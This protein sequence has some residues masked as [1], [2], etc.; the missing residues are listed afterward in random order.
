MVAAECCSAMWAC[1]ICPMR[2]GAQTKRGFCADP[3]ACASALP[4][5]MSSSARR[6]GSSR[7]GGS[8]AAD[9]GPALDPVLGAL[10]IGAGEQVYD[11]IVAGRLP[12]MPRSCEQCGPYLTHPFA[13]SP[14]SLDYDRQTRLH[15]VKLGCIFCQAVQAAAQPQQPT[16]LAALRRRPVPLATHGGQPPAGGGGGGGSVAAGWLQ[17]LPWWRLRRLPGRPSRRRR[18]LQSTLRGLHTVALADGQ[19]QYLLTWAGR[20]TSGAWFVLITLHLAMH[21]HWVT[22]VVFTSA[23][24]RAIGVGMDNLQSEIRCFPWLH[25]SGGAAAAAAADG[26]RL[27]AALPRPRRRADCA[28]PGPVVRRRLWPLGAAAF[29]LDGELLV[30]FLSEKSSQCQNCCNIGGAEQLAVYSAAGSN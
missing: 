4:Q 14:S 5:G 10:G 9:L 28:A 7:A 6:D 16:R 21:S 25:R 12:L 13:L 27:R 26:V 22:S 23:E 18:A 11:V 30:M 17:Q 8:R 20:I 2:C 15:T 24:L 3:A 19:V 1:C 29:P